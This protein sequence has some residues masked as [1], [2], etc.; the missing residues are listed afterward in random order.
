MKHLIVLLALLACGIP[1]SAQ[2]QYTGDSLYFLRPIDTMTVYSDVASGHILFDHYVAPG[3]TLFGI[4]KFYGLALEDTYTLNPKLRI[5]Y[6]AG[7]LVRTPIPRQAIRAAPAPDSLAW[8]VPVNY[9]MRK[10]ETLFGLYKR[11]LQLDNADRL[12]ALNPDLDPARMSAN[13]VLAIGYLKLDGIP[14]ALQGEVEDPYVRRNRG[15]RALWKN[16]TKGKKLI[17]ENG[18]AA[19]TRKGDRNKWMVLHRTAP[20]GTLIEIEDPR[21]RKTIYA[22]VVER[23]PE[24]VTDRDVILV[25]S[26]LLVKAFGVRDRH[27]Y[28]RTRHF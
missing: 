11:T 23:I 6:E 19:W 28:V 25:V 24:Q 4:T 26:P 1:L 5:G 16:Q 7:D 27:F 21:S 17:S 15:L 8:F 9:R 3:Q 14:E 18:K 12:Y 2:Q 10:G 22:R 13:Q 20:I